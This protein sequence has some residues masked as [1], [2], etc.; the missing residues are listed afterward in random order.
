[1]PRRPVD[2]QRKTDDGAADGDGQK[3]LQQV[4]RTHE[5]R[6]YGKGADGHAAAEPGKEIGPRVHDPRFLGGQRFLAQTLVFD[7]LGHMPVMR[8]NTPVCI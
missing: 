5:T 3:H 1:M 8:Q 7:H 4:Q 2:H 6:T